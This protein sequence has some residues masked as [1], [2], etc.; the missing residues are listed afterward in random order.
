MA[1]LP[2][3]CLS[4]TFCM[5]L[6]DIVGDKAL[7][8]LLLETTYRNLRILL[9]SERLK[10]ETSERS[11]LK[12]LGSWLGKVG[13]LKAAHCLLLALLEATSG[14]CEEFL[15]VAGLLCPVSSLQAL[16]WRAVA[17]QLYIFISTQPSVR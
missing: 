1:T 12:N 4:F 3:S 2:L 9:L 16:A 13:G 5:Q 17:L 14:S 10:T 7:Y 6:A 8:A 15:C 11:L